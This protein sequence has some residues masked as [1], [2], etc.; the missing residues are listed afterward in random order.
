MSRGKN[1]QRKPNI[2]P[3]RVSWIKNNFKARPKRRK[4]SE[5]NQTVRWYVTTGLQPGYGIIPALVARMLG[6][7]RPQLDKALQTLVN[8][9]LLSRID[10]T[11]GPISC[12]GRK[13]T[14]IRRRD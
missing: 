1:K 5:V 3:A 7:T 2:E 11:E 10:R 4:Q 6:V 14:H 12:G 8:E 9:G 13:E